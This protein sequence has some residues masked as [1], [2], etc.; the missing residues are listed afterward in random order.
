M[1]KL[2][3]NCEGGCACGY[4]RY[5]IT[6]E[7]LIT[8]CCHCRYCQ[9]Q[10]GTAFALNALFDASKVH[11]LSGS[12]DEIITPSPSGRGQKVCRCPKCEVALWSN[13]FMGGIQNLIRFIRVGTLDNPDQLPPDVH[14]YTAS[15]QPWVTLAPNALVFDKFY[16]FEN[17]W[18]NENNEFRKQLLA[19]VLEQ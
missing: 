9:R 11:I 6:S 5:K 15:K 4:V 2:T 13:Y 17:T 10:T 18:T 12:V 7:P 3:D 19:K 1:S 16:D 14:I 8:H